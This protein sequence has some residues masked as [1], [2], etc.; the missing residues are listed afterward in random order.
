[1]FRDSLFA[2]TWGRRISLTLSAISLRLHFFSLIV[3]LPLSILLISSTSLIRLRRWL[4]EV[5]ILSRVSATFSGS[6]RWEEAILV[7]P[8]IAFIGVRISWDILVRKVLLAESA[9]LALSR[10][11]SK[12]FL[13]C[14]SLL[15]SSW[16]QETPTKAL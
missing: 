10:A 13:C 12:S 4:L 14:I 16:M 1:M 6:L 7:R 2:L 11:S 9:L 15:I 5:L 8:M 3:T